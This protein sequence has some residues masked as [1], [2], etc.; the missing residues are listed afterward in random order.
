MRWLICCICLPLI[1]FGQLDHEMVRTLIDH[2]EFD[3][4]ENLLMPYVVD[5]ENLDAIELLGDI[6]GSQKEWDKAINEYQKLV[7]RQPN[8]ANYQYK[9]GGVLAMK[10]LSVNKIRALGIIDDVEEAFLTAAR[11][12][13]RHVDVKLPTILGGGFDNA[14][15]Y[16]IELERLSPVDGYLAKGFVYFNDGDYDSAETY[17]QNALKIGGSLTC[18]KKLIDFYVSQGEFQKA[19]INLKE[20]YNAYPSEALLQQKEDLERKLE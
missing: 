18:Y 1:G 4:A 9:Y 7:E 6:Y 16:A 19:I 13:S 8:V 14:M 10:A 2:E 17:Y 15:Q 3:R 5:S 11:L 20:A 12:D